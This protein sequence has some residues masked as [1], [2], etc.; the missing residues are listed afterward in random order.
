MKTTDNLILVMVVAGTLLGSTA[1]VILQQQQV[2]APRE[3]GGCVISQFKQAAHE[4][5]KNVITAVTVGNPDEVDDDLEKFALFMRS[6][7]LPPDPTIDALI[8]NYENG[9]MRIFST[10]PPDDGKPHEQIKEFKQL[11]KDFER[12]IFQQILQQQ[13]APPG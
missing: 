11:T 1:V 12:Q 8:A 2:Y 5:E 9:V 7:P 3:C 4:F 6:L 10:P 13:T